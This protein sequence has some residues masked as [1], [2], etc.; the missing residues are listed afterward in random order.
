MRGPEHIVVN[1]FN[2]GFIIQV[3]SVWVSAGVIL[4]YWFRWGMSWKCLLQCSIKCNIFVGPSCRISQVVNLLIWW[5]NKII[6]ILVELSIR[7][8]KYTHAHTRTHFRVYVRFVTDGDGTCFTHI[9]VCRYGFVYLRGIYGM[10]GSRIRA[11]RSCEV[12]TFVRVYMY[13][14]EWMMLWWWLWCGFRH[15]NDVSRLG[16]K[17]MNGKLWHNAEG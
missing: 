13:I 6:K 15:R 9:Y 10:Y 12:W 11:A 3:I 7:L 16:N 4:L 17:G 1:F 5:N 2:I 14:A 8:L